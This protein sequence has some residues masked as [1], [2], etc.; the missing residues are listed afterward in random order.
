MSA[1]AG[2][3]AIRLRGLRKRFGR[4]VALAGVDLELGGRTIVA[5]V[6]P[7]GAGKT[8]L[9]RSLAG[10]LEIEAEEASVLGFDLRADPTELKARIGY[11]PQSFSLQRE[12]TVGENLRFTARLHRLAEDEFRRRA[13][14]LLERTALAAFVDRP[15][16]KLSGGMKQKLAIVNALLVEPAIVLLDEPTAGVDVLARAEIAE[17]LIRAKEKALVVMST[18]YIDEAESVDRIVYLDDGRVVASGEP[19]TLRERAALELYRVWG[20]E[21]R[22]LAQAARRLE[23]VVAARGSGRFAR[24]EAPARG[25]SR[26]RAL[27][28]L[29]ALAGAAFVE[30]VPVDLE[31]ALVALARQGP[32]ADPRRA[33]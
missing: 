2:G 22:V 30:V 27:G 7:D 11:V 15:A 25:V 18:S 16:G 3:P 21:P 24:V 12:L 26:E 14:D 5:V 23:W 29:R 6:G 33:A 4:R 8:T 28:D 31:A 17:L 9:L 20:E 10:L 1:D 32:A 13:D 19:A